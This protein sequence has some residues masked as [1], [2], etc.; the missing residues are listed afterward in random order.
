MK[1]SQ[2]LD[3]DEP[4]EKEDEEVMAAPAVIPQQKMNT[5]EHEMMVQERTLAKHQKRMAK[6]K[7][8]KLMS[9]KELEDG[10]EEDDQMIKRLE[11]KLGLKKVRFKN[12]KNLKINFKI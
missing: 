9:K 6:S 4:D 7:K 2:I 11:R 3:N 5:I 8:P 1:N 10:I 12:S